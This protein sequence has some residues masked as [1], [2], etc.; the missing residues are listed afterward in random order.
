MLSRKD[1][2]AELL[3]DLEIATRDKFSVATPRPPRMSVEHIMPQAWTNHWALA[4][5]SLVPED[6]V[7]GVDDVM[8]GEIQAR[9]GALHTLGN[10]TL[11]T[12]PGNSAASDSEFSKTSTWLAK[13]LLALNLE[14]LEN[15][16]ENDKPVWDVDGISKRA[17]VLARRAM[18]V[19]PA[20]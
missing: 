16:R 12:T 19:W 18:S 2:L 3:W 11:I 9:D 1:R 8:R 5:G 13:A 6:R 15:G 17:T 7:T 4:D 14:V 20:P 10:L